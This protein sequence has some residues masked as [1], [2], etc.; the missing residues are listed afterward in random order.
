MCK[1]SK[2]NHRSTKGR[3]LKDGTTSRSL[4][5]EGVFP[6]GRILVWGVQMHSK[7]SWRWTSESDCGMYQKVGNLLGATLLVK[8]CRHEVRQEQGRSIVR[9]K[10]TRRATTFLVPHHSSLRGAPPQ[11]HQPSDDCWACCW[12]ASGCIFVSQE[13]IVMKKRRLVE[14]ME[15]SS[16]ESIYMLT[17]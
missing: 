17:M 1:T 2:V 16:V 4:H 6:H 12:R 3:A 8:R 7:A 5:I 13:R 11:S 9:T 10:G 15:R 14:S